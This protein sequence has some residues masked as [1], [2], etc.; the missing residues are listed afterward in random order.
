LRWNPETP[1]LKKLREQ[2]LANSAE[3]LEKLRQVIGH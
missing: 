2:L 3:T 1:E